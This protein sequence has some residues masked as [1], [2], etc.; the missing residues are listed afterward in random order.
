MPIGAAAARRDRADRRKVTCNPIHLPRHDRTG[1]AYEIH[2]GAQ[3]PCP[4]TRRKLLADLTDGTSDGC[5]VAGNCRA[6]ASGTHPLEIA[7]NPF[8]SIACC[9]SFAAPALPT[10]SVDVRTYKEQQSTTCWRP[11]CAGI[12]TWSSFIES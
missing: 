12:P 7:D 5:C 2:M 3:R 11:L 6:V 8:S 1:S 10:E 9:G 4:D